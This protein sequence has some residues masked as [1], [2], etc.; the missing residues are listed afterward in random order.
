VEFDFEKMFEYVANI[1]SHRIEENKHKFAIYIDR[2][3][4][5]ILIG[6]DQ[7]LAQIVTNLLSNAVKFT[8]E[9]G[10]IRIHTYLV[11]EEDD[12]C[13]IKIAITDTG[14]GISPEKQAELFEAF[15]QAETH[16][17]RRFGGTGLGLPIAKSIVEMMGGEI[18]VESDIGKG[19][20]FNCTV[21][22][23]RGKAEL[24]R[25]SAGSL[26]LSG[27]RVLVVD[28][29]ESILNDF[30]GIV[31][32]FGIACDTAVYGNEALQLVDDTGAYSIYFVDLK[33]SDRAGLDFIRKLKKHASVSDESLIVMVSFAEYGKI[34][35]V[36]K[37][38]GIEKVLKKP[39]FPS[40]IAGII[41][42][43]LDA[44]PSRAEED[45]SDIRGIFEGHCILLAE[46]IEINREIVVTLLEPTLLKI[47]CAENGIEAVSMFS[48]APDKYEMIFMDIQMPEM[49]GMEA[50]RRIRALGVPNSGAVPIIAMTANVFKE[51][52]DKCMDAGMN[53]HVGK[54]IDFETVL[55]LIRKYIPR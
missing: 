17:S 23:R 29:D 53:G 15:T 43:Y 52:I 7:R 16:T 13:T 9:N 35:E 36:L 3:I 19:S 4:P 24:K 21:Q 31:E 54:P 27:V 47:D 12:I 22:L 1:N 10:S 33:L 45:F 6:D 18:W 50:T 42:D 25:L 20:T 49:D 40:V 46:D 8:P 44:G 14:I 55:R 5:R 28:S 51:D 34:S 32:G 37:E 30:K 41:E 2:A 48:E 11:G 26:D 38:A 39:L